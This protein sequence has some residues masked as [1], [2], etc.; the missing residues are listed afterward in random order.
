MTGPVVMQRYI[1]YQYCKLLLL[2]RISSYTERQCKAV[3]CHLNSS[4]IQ[5]YH[6]CPCSGHISSL[7]AHFFVKFSSWIIVSVTVSCVCWSLDSQ[8]AFQKLRSCFSG[9]PPCCICLGLGRE[10][11][12][13][14]RSSCCFIC[15]PHPTPTTV[16][17]VF[18]FHDI[19]LILW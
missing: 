10:V 6:H 16:S 12:C 15:S 18:L 1:E 14:S 5:K 19:T 2:G 17:S 3:V 8:I 11:G 4:Q 7:S 13:A 9:T